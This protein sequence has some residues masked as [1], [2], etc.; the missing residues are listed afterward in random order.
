MEL[1][2][3]YLILIVKNTSFVHYLQLFVKKKGL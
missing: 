2:D 1:M 3:G